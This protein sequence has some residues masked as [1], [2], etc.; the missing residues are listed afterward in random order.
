V[1]S[2]QRTEKRLGVELPLAL[3]TAKIAYAVGWAVFQSCASAIIGD[4]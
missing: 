3:P 2:F 1:K 4:K